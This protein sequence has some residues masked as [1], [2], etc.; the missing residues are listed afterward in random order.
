[1]R[2]CLLTI[3]AGFFGLTL[4]FGEE[5]VVEDFNP[6]SQ[7]TWKFWNGNEFPGAE[8]FFEIQSKTNTEYYG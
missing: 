7:K 5:Y 1:M 8:G 2:R 4:V 6:D 3:L